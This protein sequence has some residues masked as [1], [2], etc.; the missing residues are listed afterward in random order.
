MLFVS[1]T[2]RKANPVR[3]LIPV[4]LSLICMASALGAE[5]QRIIPPGTKLAG[6]YSPGIFAGEFLY[7]AGQGA[8]DAQGQLPKDEEARIRQCLENVKSVIDAAGLTMEH[9]VYVQVYLTNYSDEGPLNRVWK[10]FFPKLPPARS[11]IG[12]AWPQ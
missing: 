1:G 9:I 8:E 2:S 11:T 5:L 12:P 10:E 6:P 7:V 4:I 3:I